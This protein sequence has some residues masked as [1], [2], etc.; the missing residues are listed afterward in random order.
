MALDRPTNMICDTICDHPDVMQEVLSKVRLLF[1][2]ISSGNIIGPFGYGV[3]CTVQID[4]DYRVL[5]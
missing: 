2:S 3:Y 5:Q 1:D 4:L